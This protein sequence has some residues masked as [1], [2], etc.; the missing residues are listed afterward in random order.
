METRR[1][2]F[3]CTSLSCAAVLAGLF[4]AL[5]AANGLK[6][7]I[8][9][10]LNEGTV[11]E[12]LDQAAACQE[13]LSVT[14]HLSGENNENNT[15]ACGPAP[16]FA[17]ESDVLDELLDVTGTELNTGN[18]VA[19]DGRVDVPTGARPSPVC[20]E[21][22][23]AQR[24]TVKMLREEEFGPVKL[25]DKAYVPPPS[26]RPEFPRP[27]THEYGPSATNL[28]E[29]LSYYV[30][31]PHGDYVPRTTPGRAY[32]YPWP[33]MYANDPDDLNYSTEAG[34]AGMENPWK[35]DIQTYLGRTLNTPPAEGRPPGPDWAHQRWDEFYP[36]TYFATAQAGA[37]TNNG[38]RD[39]LQ[40]HNY[41]LGE[42]GP[43]GLYHNIL[44]GD[45]LVNPI[46]GTTG[47]IEPRFHPRFPAQ[48]PNAL[49]TFDGTFPPKL[50]K[51]RYGEG[52]L[53]RHYNALPID[54][55]ANYGFGVHT[56]STH[57]HNGHNPSESDGYTQAFFF[58]GQFYDY[59]WPMIPAGHDSINTDASDPRMAMPCKEGELIRYKYKTGAAEMRPCVNGAVQL[60]GDYRELMG[61]HWFHDH[62]LDFTAQNVYKGN[63]SMFNYYSAIDRGKEADCHYANPY[64]PATKTGN[65]NL[66]L[67]SGK[68][69]EWGNRDYDINVLMT[70]KAWDSD[71]QLFFNIFNKDGFLGD[72]MLTNLVWKPYF[73]VR[74]RRY[75]LRLLN[76]SVS[77][78][79]RIALVEQVNGTSGEI[80]GPQRSNVSYNRVPFHMV[81]NDGNIMEHA[82]HFDGNKTVAGFENR[83]GTL[84][85]QAIAERYDIVVDFA[86]FAPGTKL[87]FVNLLEHRN[88][89][90]PNEAI[91]LQ[92]ILNGTYHDRR[93]ASAAEADIAIP[94]GT[95]YDTDPTVGRFLEF[96]VHRNIDP[97][98]CVINPDNSRDA[99]VICQDGVDTSMNPADYEEGGMKMVPLPGFTQEELANAVHRTFE[100]A[101]SNG[102]DESLWSIK[103]DGGAGYNMDP[104]RLTAAPTKDGQ[105]EIWHLEGN[106]GWS[107][108]V[109]VH[110]EEGQILSRDGKAPPEWEKW[111]R[112]DIYRIGR[113]ADS[114]TSVSLAIRFREFMGTYMEHCHNTQ[115]E[116][117]AMLLRWDVENPNQVKLMPTPMPTWDG[118][119]YV[120]STALPTARRNGNPGPGGGTETPANVSP[121]VSLSPENPVGVEPFWVLFGGPASDLDGTI[122]SRTWAFGDGATSNSSNV[123]LGHT[124][125]AAGTYT[126]TVTVTDNGGATASASTLVTVAAAPVVDTTAPVVT[127]P[128]DIW[129]VEG[130]S[131]N[132]VTATATDDVGVV[133]I[134]NDAPETF[135]LGPTL[136]TW[137]AKDAANNTG[138]ATQ[139]VTVTA[140]ASNVAPVAVNDAYTLAKGTVVTITAG[141]NVTANDTDDGTLNPSSVVITSQNLTKGG[142]IVQTAPG[143]WTYTVGSG[144]VIVGRAIVD[145]GESFTYT[146]LDNLGQVSNQATVTVTVIPLP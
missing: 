98:T 39:R 60:P 64:N 23:C 35:A 5:S 126:A 3:A 139:W 12:D 106:G 136:V 74:K 56:L 118:V 78:Y 19:D 13:M 2:N 103:T 6:A 38:L 97:S 122:V 69:L 125:T 51:A 34:E 140:A 90:R 129:I 7:D 10:P 37:R 84:P 32:P 9:G 15:T 70:D 33:T 123:T 21:G 24:F 68:A 77:R 128:A 93:G 49:W 85:T 144:R 108:P 59:H 30:D 8:A 141:L 26:E 73:D 127:A 76:A 45:G 88:G 66:C 107:H 83:K 114:T 46:V 54:P 63:V 20:F 87:Y 17:V 62:M 132:L 71:G 86:R 80:S 130:D 131:I 99:P 102:T 138:T 16:Q 22:T 75:R 72:Q 43:F 28:D 44:E 67:P 61:T 101:R 96:R 142:L 116:D 146:V 31:E 105:V 55:A 109:H 25:G 81:L 100:F 40:T 89:R 48:D 124:Y 117:H 52:V 50:L 94:N 65:V 11:S 95:R 110:F 143:V 53:F 1:R 91:P 145:V 58:P 104:R 111:A 112:K 41:A 27:Q 120:A 29:F 79:L 4:F 57:E 92:D 113:M 82:V 36:Q 134:T 135:P 115:H 119:G 18:I 14:S 137:T 121:T 42:W 47:G 133:S